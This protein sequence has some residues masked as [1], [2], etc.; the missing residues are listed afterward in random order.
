[1][2]CPVGSCKCP[3]GWPWL[4]FGNFED[5]GWWATS[6]ADLAAP[7]KACSQ[8]FSAASQ[9]WGENCR[10]TSTLLLF[11]CTALRRHISGMVSRSQERGA[12]ICQSLVSVKQ[13]R[14]L[15][16]SHIRAA[17]SASL[18]ASSRPPKA[19]PL[20]VISHASRDLARI[21][22]TMPTTTILVATDLTL[23]DAIER[24]YR[25]GYL[26]LDS[27]EVSAARFSISIVQWDRERERF[28]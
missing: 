20:A 27:S 11:S 9:L 10:P 6:I 26:H 18:G 1:M 24:S 14:I 21:N 17:S 5:R 13:P 4:T 12:K 28:R 3:N 15:D 25:R 7:I 22:A 2:L 19:C 23:G 8:R 16:W